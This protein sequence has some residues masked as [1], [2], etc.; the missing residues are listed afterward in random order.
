MK[1]ALHLSR[2]AALLLLAVLCVGLLSA[3]GGDP[4]T[5]GKKRDYIVFYVWGDNTELACYEAIAAQYKEETGMTVKVQPAT[6]EYYDNL[7]IAF[8]SKENAPDI[9]FTESGEFLSHMASGKMLDLTPYIESGVLDIKTSANADGKI[10]LWDVNDAYRYNGTAVGTGAYYALIKD[11]SPDF[12]MW[13]NKSH[14]DAYN[15]ENGFTEGDAGYMAYP[16]SEV[17]MTWD[18]FLDMS[19]KLRKENR[20]GTMLDRVPYK[21]LMEWIQMTGASTWTGD[22][23]YFNAS[24][25][26]VLDAFEFFTDLQIGDQ[27]SAPVV[28]PTGVGSGEAFANGNVSFVFYGNWAYS[29]Y[30]WDSV[31]FEIGYCPSPVPAH[32]DGTPLT[33]DDVYAGSCGM[34]ALAVNGESA[35]KDEAVAFLNYY[36]TKG[37]E[38]M[39]SRGFNIPGNKA[40]ANSDVYRNPEDSTLA[41]INQYF[42]DIA[43]NYTHAIVYNK[44]MGQETFESIVGRYM[45]AYLANPSSTTLSQV[46]NSI[47]E[48]VR[49]E[50]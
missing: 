17:P 43:T 18:A 12:V 10:E 2:L 28:G 34:T 22:N 47:A 38:Y 26:R 41:E 4:S 33:K 7:N 49:R 14:I 25:E 15:A 46:L 9:F 32:A 20:Y 35:M 6:G 50:M 31:G 42:L 11:W 44:Y 36:M 29:T 13:Y 30:S 19:H 21:H 3:C 27:A 37:N 39:A 16:S 1:K 24:D 40:V 45:S 5:G 23:Q 8:S 48:D